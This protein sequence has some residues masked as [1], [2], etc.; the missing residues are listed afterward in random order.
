M[1]NLG[2]AISLASQAF[3]N[4]KDKGGQP[5]ILH[6]IRVMNNLHTEDEELKCIAILHDYIEDIFKDNPEKGLMLLSEIGFSRRVVQALN[7]LTHRKET[8]YD[9]YIKAI[10]FNAD[11]TK[12]KLADLKDNSDI[13]RLK[14]L[15]KK[16]FDRMEKYHRSYVYLS[17]I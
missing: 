7:L 14:G 11:A 8:P 1:S 9:D 15:T 10:S 5:Y 2:K 16:D 12:V 17:K 13:T 4:V 3:E 6:C